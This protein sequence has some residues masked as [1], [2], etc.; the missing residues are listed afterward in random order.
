MTLT[1]MNNV[2]VAVIELPKQKIEAGKISDAGNLTFKAAT[3]T[4]DISATGTANSYIVPDAGNYKFPLVQG[5]ST[6]KVDAA[7]VAVL[8]ETWNNK[9]EVAAGSIVKSVAIEDGYAVVEIA[10]P[11]HPGNALIAAKASDGTILWT[12]HLWL[13]QTPVA[14]VNDPEHHFFATNAMDR[15]LGALI[16]CPEIKDGPAPE[17]SYGLFY[18]WG[19]KDPFTGPFSVN[20]TEM[21]DVTEDV[22][23]TAASIANPTMLTTGKSNNWNAELLTD[24]WDMDGNKTI[25]DPC[26]AGYRVPV[27]NTD[28]KLWIKRAD[29]DWTFDVEHFWMKFNELGIVFPVC[30]YLSG[31]HSLSKE[32]VRALIWSATPGLGSEEEP[33]GSAGFFDISRDSGK[34]YYHSYFKYAAG[35]V[36]C[37]VER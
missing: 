37:V 33:R 6:T 2:A 35:S 23:S 7:S 11:F 20:G 18:Q 1:D 28:F 16:V 13:P 19:R 15:N 21:A 36:R 22:L 17:A 14:T 34:Y 26:P 9:D 8:W 27:Y 5:N 12:W 29:D 4:I 25:Y 30:G 10:E 3:Q 31:G 32:G 24:L